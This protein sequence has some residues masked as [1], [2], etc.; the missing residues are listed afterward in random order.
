MD[1][2][3]AKSR[4]IG[5]DFRLVG[6]RH[7]VYTSSFPFGQKWKTGISR[8]EP[9][10]IVASSL[11]LFFSQYIFIMPSLITRKR[12]K[13]LLA[14]TIFQ[15]P[16]PAS[17]LDIFSPDFTIFKFF[18]RLKIWNRGEKRLS[19]RRFGVVIRN[20]RDRARIR[21]GYFNVETPPLFLSLS[22]L[23]PACSFID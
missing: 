14:A 6:V 10:C 17:I 1:S 23:P 2:G 21:D 7:A 3:R 8:N 15:L 11:P 22:L 16:R 4:G 19:C 12:L 9:P 20:N 18:C 13:L 5:K